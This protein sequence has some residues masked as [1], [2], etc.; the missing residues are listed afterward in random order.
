MK[1]VFIKP[2]MGLVSGA[3]Y[4]DHGRMEPLTFAV[5]AGITPPQH[6][7][8]LYD[9][10]FERLPFEEHMDLVAINTEIYTARRAYE[11]ADRFRNRGIPVVLG[12]F[13]TTLIPDESLEHA[14]AVVLGDAEPVWETL[15]ADLEKGRLRRRYVG[16]F[17][18]RAP[19]PHSSQLIGIRTD[20]SIFVA[21]KYLPVRL[22][23]FSR[24]CVNQCEYCATGNIYR[25]HHCCR[26]VDEVVRELSRDGAR[27]VFFVDDN[28][29]ASK[30]Q[31]RELFRRLRPMRIRWFGQADLSFAADPAF[32]ELML[33]SGCSGLV[34]GFESLDQR[35]LVQM[36]K[37]CNLGFDT[38]DPMVE[39]IR[40]SGLMLWAAFLLGYDNETPES[41]KATCDWALS[42]KFAFSAFNILMPYPGTPLYAR[43]KKE[44]RLLYD[45]R[46]WLHDDYRFGM[47]GFRP[48]NCSP[49]ELAQACLE[50]RRR[51]S[52]I[53]SIFRR[54]CDRKTHMKDAWSLAT[55]FS[56]N[57]VFRDEMLKKH[58]MVLGYRGI[59]RPRSVELL[60]K[61]AEPV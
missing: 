34:V 18:G 50:A 2:N 7:T 45:G 28:L 51:H 49:D 46:W 43:M 10:R 57:P 42:K 38:Y 26:P 19:D 31:A 12:G 56:Y 8:V 13:H 41:V 15:L 30:E 1:I 37:N 27:F 59:E 9:D 53:P 14:D 23:Q 21:K 39:A 36:Q 11:I 22:T 29:I 48:R 20:W 5:L 3:P 47:P 61:G 54:A 6:E 25:Q 16:S 32:M 24:G 60:G 17:G 44:G 55:Y 33:E 35:N 58:G 52:S 40:R 4:D